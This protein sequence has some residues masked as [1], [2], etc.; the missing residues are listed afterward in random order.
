LPNESAIDTLLSQLTHL[1]GLSAPSRHINQWPAEVINQAALRIQAI[2]G[3]LSANPTLPGSN[4]AVRLAATMLLSEVSLFASFLR[5]TTNQA[6][7]ELDLAYEA[8][9]L[10]RNGVESRT[11]TDA[12][13]LPSS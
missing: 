11:A 2:Q 5:T 13:R 8:L 4:P 7:T 10:V 6:I 12:P 3:W 1:G 9:V